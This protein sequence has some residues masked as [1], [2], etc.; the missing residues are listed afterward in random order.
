MDIYVFLS[1]YVYVLCV[2][3]NATKIFRYRSNN[4]KLILMLRVKF[5]RDFLKGPG[6]NK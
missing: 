4:D 3:F 2:I 1:K 5:H 6:D